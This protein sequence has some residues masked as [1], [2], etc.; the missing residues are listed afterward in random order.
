M[1]DSTYCSPFPMHVISG[2]VMP[3]E[4]DLSFDPKYFL[5]TIVCLIIFSL[6]RCMSFEILISLKKILLNS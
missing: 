1:W 6:I 3:D 2:S 4:H 5:C